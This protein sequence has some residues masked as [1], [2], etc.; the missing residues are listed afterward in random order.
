[1]QSKRWAGVIV[2]LIVV[3]I[4][5]VDRINVSLMI[6][7]ADF[8]HTLGLEGDRVAQGRLVSLF[9]FGYGLSAWF[10]TPVFESHWSVRTSLLI[11]V[12]LWTVFTAASA[13]AAGA[14]VFLL[15]RLL[16]GCAEG[17]LFSLKTI[18]VKEHFAAN[19]V[20]KPN[21]VSSLGVSIG[22]G[23]GYSI[24]NFLIMHFGWRDSIWALA[25][26]N[27][28]IGL[29]LI[30][31]FIRSSSTRPRDAGHQADSALA[32]LLAALRT[33]HL[34]WILIVEICTLSYL[35]G[36]S[37]WLPS[38]LKEARHF[39]LNEMSIFAGLPFFVGIIAN[40]A[41]GSV[42]DLLPRSKAP[43]VFAIGGVTTAISVTTAIVADN[44]YVAASALILAGAGW[45]F[46]APAIPTLVQHVA[47]HGT[48]GSTYG[49]IN[50]IGNLTSA[51]MPMMMG[52]AMMSRS[53]DNLARGFWLLVGAQLLTAAC[54]LVLVARLTRG[55]TE[56]SQGA[57]LA[58]D[59]P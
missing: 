45:G 30:A 23:A 42:V 7:N 34:F 18:Y 11:S 4:A 47:K 41:G 29:P 37:T 38:Y 2:I 14:T 3:S 16:L 51:L 10:L 19:E 31:L 26:L 48:V 20:G 58:A 35:W 36:A 5:Y 9:L 25:A 56:A 24:V 49:L 40:V 59:S 43:V 53:G 44:P 52:A 33:P 54:G 17:P 57:T 39:S 8:L 15:L 55:A 32:L 6:T 28:V 50:G 22:L 46:Q 12:L 21:A 1:M 13:L 27:I